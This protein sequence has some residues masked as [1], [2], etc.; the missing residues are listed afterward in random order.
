MHKI[1]VVGDKDSVLAFKAIG[2]DVFPVVEAE[3]ARKAIDKMAYNDYAVIF[4]T[5]Q[6]AQH[7][8]ETIERYNKK[9]LPSIILI[10]SNQ[11]TLNI[12]KKRIS[13][14]VEKAVGVNIL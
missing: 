5:E 3:E 8:D 6:L 12:G 13:D 4:V 1:G 11:G 2:I 10:P 7:L 14:N 9:L